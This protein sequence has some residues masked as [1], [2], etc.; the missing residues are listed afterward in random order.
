MLRRVDGAS[1]QNVTSAAEFLLERTVVTDFVIRNESL[2]ND[3]ALISALANNTILRN[4]A[5]SIDDRATYLLGVGMTGASAMTFQENATISNLEVH[6]A[7]NASVVLWGVSRIIGYTYAGGFTIPPAYQNIHFL[8]SNSSMV[9]QE[10]SGLVYIRSCRDA[11]NISVTFLNQS[12][13]VMLQPPDTV[14]RET[15]AMLTIVGFTDPTRAI[16]LIAVL[17][18]NS[19]AIAV[20]TT[21]FGSTSPLSTASP[22]SLGRCVRLVCII[23]LSGI[24]R[25]P[26]MIIRSSTAPSSL[27]SPTTMMPIWCTS[28]QVDVIVSVNYRGMEVQ[29]ANIVVDS[30]DLIVASKGFFIVAPVWTNG[31]V[32]IGPQALCGTHP[33]SYAAARRPTP[34]PLLQR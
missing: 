1:L 9:Q 14:R 23:G 4:I 20:R 3:T 30:V 32:V 11:L 22:S 25:N 27:S 13:I 10:E 18:E 34:S 31:F 15:G 7:N 21:T 16:D 2:V 19:D 33:S 29:Q 24:V 12:K 6:V 26:S 28:N 5:I 17:V 8:I